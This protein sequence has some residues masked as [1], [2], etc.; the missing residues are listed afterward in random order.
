MHH[1]RTEDLQPAA[2]TAA[3]TNSATD[4]AGHGRPDAR[5]GEGEVIAHDPNTPLGTEERAGEIFDRALQVGEA[6]VV[7]DDQ[8]L[9]L[10]ELRTV[11]G[12]RGVAPVDGSGGDDAD[13]GRVALHEPDLHRRGMGAQEQVVGFDVEAVHGV[14]RRMVLGDVERLEIVELV[15]HLRSKRDLVAEARKD[16][17]H[18]PEDQR[19]GV[20]MAAADRVGHKGQVEPLG[21]AQGGVPLRFQPAHAVADPLEDLVFELVRLCSGGGP[22]GRWKAAELSQDGGELAFLPEQAHAQAF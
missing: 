10:I 18:L 6:D 16:R 8:A 17:L 3:A 21:F 5:L 1:P 12:I 9:D 20:Q 2:L 14:T 13:R 11:R 15:L 7:V 22:V 19:E 4:S